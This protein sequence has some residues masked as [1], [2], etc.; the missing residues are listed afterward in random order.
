VRNRFLP[1]V[2]IIAV[3]GFSVAGLLKLRFETDIL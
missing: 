2:L 1:I 3:I